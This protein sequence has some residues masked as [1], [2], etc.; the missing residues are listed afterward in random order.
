MTFATAISPIIQASASGETAS[1]WPRGLAR[2]PRLLS[3]LFIGAHVASIGLVVPFSVMANMRYRSALEVGKELFQ[4][5][6]VA[7]AAFETDQTQTVS[8][9]Q[10][11]IAGLLAEVELVSQ[12][13]VV[14]WRGVWIVYDCLNGILAIVRRSD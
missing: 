13:F 2:H 9:L 11:T 14:C 12:R 6:A 3:T 10:V 5:L 7:T 4:Q 8:T 1:R